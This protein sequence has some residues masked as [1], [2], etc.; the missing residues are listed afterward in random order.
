M[1]RKRLTRIVIAD[2]HHMTLA[3]L[4]AT[5]N[6]VDDFDVVGQAADG[7]AVLALARSLRPDMLLVDVEMPRLSGVDVVRTL[8]ARG[9]QVR[10]LA[11]SAYDEPEYVYGL[12]DAGASGY[13]MKEEADRDMLVSAVRGV[14]AG[15]DLW[16]SPDLAAQLVR[17]QVVPEGTP[18]EE[19]SERE[20]DVLRLVADGLDNYQAAEALFIS[21]HTV[22]NHLEHIK[23][24]LEVRTRAEVIAWA[25]HNRIVR[26]GSAGRVS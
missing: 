5:L 19:L 3:G 17:R 8:R 20:M 24:K 12:L 9:D 22:K 21:H 11:L 13:L 7:E 15:E 16:I 14:L 4:A 26:P 23:G 18:Q 2:D 1:G 6:T 25:W 10:V